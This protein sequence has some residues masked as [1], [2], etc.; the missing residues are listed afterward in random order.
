MGLEFVYVKNDKVRITAEC[1]HRKSQDCKWCVHASLEKSGGFFC[2][3]SFYN[4]YTC[5]AAVRT[6]KSSRISSEIVT[7]LM[8]D[9]IREKPLTRPIDV[10]HHFNANYGLTIIYH[11]AWWGVERARN[12]L[13]D[14]SLSFYHLR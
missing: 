4:E 13:Y 3:R 10:V 2:I 14:T 5:G 7:D 8:V 6:S 12:K 9:H 1:S 11:H